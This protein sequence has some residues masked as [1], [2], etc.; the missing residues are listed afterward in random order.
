MEGIATHLLLAVGSI[1]MLLP[2]YWMLITSVKQEWE[3]YQ[4]PPQWL[5]SQ[6]LWSNYT[7]AFF[8]YF[9]FPLYG[10]NT[11]IITVGVMV[12]RL[13]SASLVAYG[14]ARLR[15]IGRDILFLV[16]LGT[17][18]I[19][20]QVTI[21]P[22]YI[23]YNNLHWLNT[24]FPLIVPAWFGG[25]AFYIFLLRQFMMT[26]SPELDDAARIDG[27]GWFGIYWRIVMPLIKPALGAVAIFSFLGTWN[28]FWGPL[29]FLR[30]TS[31]YTL[32]V[33][34]HFMSTAASSSIRPT[35]TIVMAGSTMIMLPPLL[36]FFFAQRYFIQGVVVSGV[37][38]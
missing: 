14:F 21:I 15:F 1:A 18:M 34:L 3:A 17:M 37:K 32:A 19:P 35:T 4:I 12:G 20:G 7:R 10:R 16:V 28:D 9:S 29:I 11:L 24:Y 31:M 2:L 30:K 33:G 13:L 25:G 23:L 8:D 27:C 6:F 5:P 38:G 36:L 26:I 22:L